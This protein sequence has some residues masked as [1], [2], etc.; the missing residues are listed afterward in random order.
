MANYHENTTASARTRG[1]SPRKRAQGRL[2]RTQARELGPSTARLRPLRIAAP[3][4]RSPA[5][6][7]AERRVPALE[8]A[9][10]AL[11]APTS[12]EKGALRGVLRGL[13]AP[14]AGREAG[15]G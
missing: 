6:L 4:R 15:E 10:G 3:I 11:P 14:R 1:R 7:A 9:K 13:R 2:R 8:R 12:P 5:G